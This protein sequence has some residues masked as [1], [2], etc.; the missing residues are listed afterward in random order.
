[1]RGIDQHIDTLCDEI[2]GEANRAAKAADANRYRVRYRRSRAAGE[3]QRHV[4]VAA[5][6]E[7]FAQHAG[8]RGAAEN[9]DAWQEFRHV[10]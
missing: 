3:R 2:I 5:L 1:M 9:E 6:G 10:F 8:F 7:T 4:E